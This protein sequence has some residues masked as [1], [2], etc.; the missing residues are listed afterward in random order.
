MNSLLHPLVM[1][2]IPSS[3]ETSSEIA[4][5]SGQQPQAEAII[6]QRVAN[7][8]SCLFTS[9]DF[10]ITGQFNANASSQLRTQ[11]VQII[12][13][14][15]KY[16]EL[17]LGMPVEEYCQWILR[18]TSWG[19][20][21][22]IMILAELNGVQIS[23]IHLDSLTLLTYSP[24]NPQAC[25]RIYLLYTGQHYDALL[26]D[27]GT[28]VFSSPVDAAALACATRYKQAW[29]AE[30]RTRIRKRIKC[31]GKHRFPS[32]TG[33]L[34]CVLRLWSSGSGREGV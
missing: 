7:D 11:C 29:D 33:D 21:V 30:L 19:G 24:S 17:R 5:Q 4:A 20:E 1:E 26:G 10:L 25:G 31:L 14:D 3:T 2:C 16:D 9:I 22:E 28:R 34:N 23:V 27:R 18:D 13:T 32:L 15:P 6:R 12:S 8:N